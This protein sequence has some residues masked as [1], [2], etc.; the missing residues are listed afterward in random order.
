MIITRESLQLIRKIKSPKIEPL[1]KTLESREKNNSHSHQEQLS[2]ISNF[3]IVNN[4]P[5]IIDELIALEID[6]E[7][8]I[9][10]LRSETMLAVTV[11]Y[12]F[13]HELFVK[14]IE[15]G[16]KTY[17]TEKPGD[18]NFYS[19]VLYRSVTYDE[20]LNI[21]YLVNKDICSMQDALKACYNQNKL[22]MLQYF[23]ETCNQEDLEGFKIYVLNTPMSRQQEVTEL[24]GQIVFLTV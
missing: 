9:D 20:F 23:L 2:R 18:A 7:Q 15:A 16:A 12:P 21:T 13:Y 10:P 6:L 17:C 1:L 11:Q 24:I 8:K 3:A 14:L 5:E 19:N 22:H 4:F